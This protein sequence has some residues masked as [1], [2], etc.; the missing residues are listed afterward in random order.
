MST[1]FLAA[2]PTWTHRR[3]IKCNLPVEG[4]ESNSN[5]SLVARDCYCC[6]ASRTMGPSKG[7][8][9]RRPRASLCGS[10]TAMSRLMTPE[11]STLPK[12]RDQT[13][14]L[15]GLIHEGVCVSVY[16]H[17]GVAEIARRLSCRYTKKQGSHDDP[18]LPRD[19]LVSEDH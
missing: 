3:A 6:T 1:K 10:S 13:Q 18:C 4:N 9:W 2:L 5:P 8:R 14:S 16:I 12:F 17:G 19:F 11:E 7:C 15:A